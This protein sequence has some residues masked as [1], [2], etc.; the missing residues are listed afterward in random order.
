MKRR[1]ILSTEQLTPLQETELKLTFAAASW[2]HWLPNTWLIVDQTNTVT[3]EK[4]R[5][6]FRKVAFDKQCLVLEIEPKGWASMEKTT[7]HGVLSDW[8]KSTLF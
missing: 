3:V 2:W 8:V 6:G 5:D 4:I 7:P 1:F